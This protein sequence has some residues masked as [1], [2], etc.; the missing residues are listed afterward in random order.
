MK[1][2][3]IIFAVFAL[4]MLLAPAMADTATADGWSAPVKLA[5]GS[6]PVLN[7]DSSG[8]LSV[9]FEGEKQ[10]MTAKLQEND[11]WT[12]PE[13]I[14]PATDRNVL[15]ISASDTK[16]LLENISGEILLSSVG[17]DGV[18]SKKEV[19]VEKQEKVYLILLHFATDSLGALHLLYGRTPEYTSEAENPGIDI[20]YRR[21]SGNNWEKELKVAEKVRFSRIWQKPG[22]AVNSQGRVFVSSYRDL[23]SFDT[24]G[25]V[26]KEICP[27]ADFAMPQAVVANGSDT[28]HFVYHASLEDGKT[29]DE[30]LCYVS[31]KGDDW[32]T[33]VCIGKQ[34]GGR[35]H[36]LI[37]TSSGKL[38]VAWEDPEGSIM[39]SRK[40]LD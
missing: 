8:I 15:Q 20:F 6:E 7:L 33:P 10:A 12:G 13:T 23:Y 21:Y 27:I 9:C 37:I 24:S 29:I 28:L 16:W 19:V 25:E 14:A 5:S 22:I 1:L 32:N 26:R 18:L 4:F 3:K 39:I 11:S 30:N 40:K 38:Y 36:S 34:L 2:K 31:K 17:P 35:S